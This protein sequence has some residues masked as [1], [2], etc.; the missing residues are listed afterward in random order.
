MPQYWQPTRSTRCWCWTACPT[1]QLRAEG[2]PPMH[3]RALVQDT[4]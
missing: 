2:V 4:A 1:A 3:L